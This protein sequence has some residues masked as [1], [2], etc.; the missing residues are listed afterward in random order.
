RLADALPATI[1]WRLT[2]AFAVVIAVIAAFVHL[3]F[4]ARFERQA[5]RA[6][7]ARAEGIAS[8]AAFSARSA[9]VFDDPESL[10]ASLR[11][12]LEDPAVQRIEVL[13]P[14]GAPLSVLEQD[15]APSADV[16]RVEVPIRF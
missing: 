4:P 7:A 1:R 10:E 15:R 13:L 3:Y 6:L 11:G 16:L 5:T 2:L 8:M 9:V 14:S 12:A